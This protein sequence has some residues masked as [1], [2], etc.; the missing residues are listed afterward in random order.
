[1][2]N[3]FEKLMGSPA[4]YPKEEFDIFEDMSSY[5]GFGTKITV[6]RAKP[7]F[8]EKYIKNF[9]KYEWEW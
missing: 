9:G 3:W 5:H 1:M 6:Y 8:R 2:A 4:R 7:K